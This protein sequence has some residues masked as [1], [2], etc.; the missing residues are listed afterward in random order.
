MHLICTEK[1]PQSATGCQEE[2]YVDLL[3]PLNLSAHNLNY[4]VVHCQN[5]RL[6][7]TKT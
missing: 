6:K 4:G 7:P 5:R 3:H 1:P 2:K